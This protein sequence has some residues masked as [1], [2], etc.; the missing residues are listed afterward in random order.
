MKTKSTRYAVKS[1]MMMIATVIALTSAF[2]V[3]VSAGMLGS[4]TKSKSIFD[5]TATGSLVVYDTYATATT[6]YAR[7]GSNISIN[8]AVNAKY[9][10]GGKD[11]LLNDYSNS[12]GGGATAQVSISVAEQPN[13]VFLEVNGSHEVRN[14]VNGMLLSAG[15]W[16]DFTK[17]IR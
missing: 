13:A 9:R 2:L 10:F 12:M 15:H 6:S 14:Y 7:S 11:I 8:A 5:T 16:L 3:T 1:I 4:D 17:W